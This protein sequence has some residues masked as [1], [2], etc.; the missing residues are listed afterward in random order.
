M[1]RS[2]GSNIANISKDGMRSGQVESVRQPATEAHAVSAGDLLVSIVQQVAAA[3]LTNDASAAAAPPL[4]DEVVEAVHDTRTSVRRLRAYLRTFRPLLDLPWSTE[5]SIELRWY[6]EVLSSVR[7]L[8]VIHA[9]LVHAHA[10]QNRT[11][12]TIAL[13]VMLERVAE[14]RLAAYRLYVDTRATPRAEAFRRQLEL[15]P[16]SV[17]LSAKGS[18][19]TRTFLPMV[20][21]AKREMQDAM[22]LVQEDPVPDHIHQ[23]RIKAKGL[24]YVCD[25]LSPSLG[26]YYSRMAGDAK[27]IQDRLGRVR[28]ASNIC[29][30]LEEAAVAD[31]R[32][33]FTAGKLW[34]LEN[35]VANTGLR[36]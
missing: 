3:I 36:R 18:Q 17:P 1:G 29:Q 8:D 34:M 35:D 15:V 25:A 16:A 6:Q 33:G 27:K 32:V 23:A 2:G 14:Q 4:T 28:D 30:W 26:R 7:D 31:P 13:Q 11:E 9:W 5:L 22:R 20:R 12:D 10:T 24:R 19:S 21:K